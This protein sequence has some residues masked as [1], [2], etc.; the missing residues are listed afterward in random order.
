[1]ILKLV[2]LRKS[3]RRF[4]MKEKAF[5]FFMTVFGVVTWFAIGLYVF[6][7]VTSPLIR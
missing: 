5:G 7:V 3:E 4:D 1:M 2:N 6:A